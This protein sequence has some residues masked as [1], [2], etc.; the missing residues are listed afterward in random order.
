MAILE[1]KKCKGNHLTIKCKFN[2]KD[3]NKKDY[4]KKDYNKKDYNKKDYN[5]KDYNRQNGDRIR[6]VKTSVKISNLPN[7]LTIDELNYLVR[8]WGYIGNINFGKSAHKAAYVDFY[9]KDEAEYFVH[10]LDRTPFDNLIISVH[11]N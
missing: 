9:N 10:A 3:Y 1:C 11:I 4:N 6:K 8:P 5:K 2:K 7:D